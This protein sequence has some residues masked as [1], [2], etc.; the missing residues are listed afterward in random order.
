MIPESIQD[1]EATAA[2]DFTVECVGKPDIPSPLDGIRFV[3]EAERISVFSDVRILQSQAAAGR[4]LPAFE[5]AGPRERLF[6]DPAW[7]RAGIVTCGGLCPGINDVIRALVNTLWYSYGVQSILGFQYGFR[8]LIPAHGLKP[9]PLDPDV[10]D[11][12]HENGGS[13][14]GSSRGPQD[15]EGMVR[16]LERLGIN[17][18]FG[19]GGDGTLRGIRDMARCVQEKKRPISIVGIPKTI[20]NDISFTDR[21]FGFET[22]VYA[23][24]PVISCAHDEAKGAYNGIG[25]IRLMGR[26]SGF[27]AA[28][29]TLA[30]SVV[31]FCMVPEVP[32]E[33]A[34]PRGFLRALE[35]RLIKKHH[36][37]IVV[38]EGA[39]QQLF[40]DESEQRDASGNVLHH[41][42]G[43]F[44][45]RKIEEYLTA[46]R[47]EHHVKYFDPSYQVRSVPA[48]GTDAIFCLHLAENAVHAA[49]AGRTNV[50]IGHWHERFTHVPIELAV[51]QRRKINPRGQLWQ[52]VLAV[53]RQSEYWRP[54]VD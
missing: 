8:G 42:I 41:D 9:V 2:L 25:L 10:V 4:P 37:V 48:R 27:I 52:S 54:A 29:A 16:T 39:G 34:G 28:A 35:Q 36:A 49:M 53:N 43:L 26:D 38:A 3:D 45:R 51:R 21:T 13:I 17:C 33:L 1:A 31:N 19:I 7:T 40:S 32:F 20:D 46:E 5:P 24:A 14:L 6:H 18:L 12:I 50:V 22:A 47:V 23:A 30:N 11:Q 44:L 15:T